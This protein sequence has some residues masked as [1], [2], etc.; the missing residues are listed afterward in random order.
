MGWMGWMGVLFQ[1]PVHREQCICGAESGLVISF[2]WQRGGTSALQW[3]NTEFNI[4][5]LLHL[6]LVVLVCCC[7]WQFNIYLLLHLVYSVDMH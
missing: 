7:I 5:L 4:Y 3:Q 1:L 6:V 2:Y